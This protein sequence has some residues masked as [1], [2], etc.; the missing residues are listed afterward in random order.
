MKAIA[1]TVTVMAA[2][3]IAAVPV[4]A[5]EGGMVQQDQ[6]VQKDECL[7]VAK[8]CPTDSIQERIQRIQTEIGKGSDVYTNDELRRLNR[9]LEVAQ[10]LLDFEM[11]NTGR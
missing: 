10:R 9:E 1:K 8:N 3:M 6:L 11:T 2:V 7:L 5:L 4:F